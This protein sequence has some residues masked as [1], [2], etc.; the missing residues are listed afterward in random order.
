MVYESLANKNVLHLLVIIVSDRLKNS[1]SKKKVWTCFKQTI[2]LFFSPLMKLVEQTKWFWNEN[3]HVVVPKEKKK[4]QNT[5]QLISKRKYP[6]LDASYNVVMEENID[7]FF[8]NLLFRLPIWEAWADVLYT[9]FC[10]RHESEVFTSIKITMLCS[11]DVQIRQ[12]STGK[13]VPNNLVL[14]CDKGKESF[15]SALVIA[16]T[17]K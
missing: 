7:F 2:V 1:W 14:T 3:K 12:R 10:S 4:N 17:R 5:Q 6:G 9:C 16:P 15:F 13:H 11:W 8:P